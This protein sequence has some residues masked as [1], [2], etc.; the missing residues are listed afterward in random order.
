MTVTEGTHVGVTMGVVVEEVVAVVD[1]MRR[2]VATSQ[3]DLG[4]DRRARRDR[5]GEVSHVNKC[6][7]AGP[8]QSHAHHPHTHHRRERVVIVRNQLLAD[9]PDRPLNDQCHLHR[10]SHHPE[11][12]TKR[13]LAH[14]HSEEIASL[15]IMV[16]VEVEVEAEVEV[17]VVVL[18]RNNFTKKMKF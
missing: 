16:T 10:P 15:L 13:N 11:A 6:P 4:H 7:T 1:T 2:I 5:R 14:H 8:S 17:V 9:D 12:T 18:Q 3:D